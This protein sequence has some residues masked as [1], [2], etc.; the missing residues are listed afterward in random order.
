MPQLLDFEL[1][2]MHWGS[3]YQANEAGRKRIWRAAPITT[4]P[5]HHLEDNLDFTSEFAFV[6]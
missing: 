6:Y 4:A 3:S 1:S 2:G 5:D